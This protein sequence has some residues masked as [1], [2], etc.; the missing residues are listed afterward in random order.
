L[1]KQ[2]YR[3]NTAWRESRELLV[4]SREGIDVTAD[5]LKG[6]DDLISPLV[7]N[8]QSIAPSVPLTRKRFIARN[9]RFTNYFDKNYLSACNLDLPRKVRYKNRRKNK[10]IQRIMLF[11]RVE[12]MMIFF[13]FRRNTYR[14]RLRVS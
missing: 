3:A 9:G 10:P 13:C 8:G 6:L 14:Q 5:E 4:S 1:E 12:P 11:A 7:K 2:Y